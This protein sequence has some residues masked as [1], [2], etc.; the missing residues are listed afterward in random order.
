M[1]GRTPSAVN[2]ISHS[3]ITI[4]TVPFCPE[5]DASLSPNVGILCSNMRTFAIRRPSSSSV[6][7]TRSTIPNWPFFGTFD[8]SLY[9]ESWTIPL[10]GAATVDVTKPINT[11]L[12]SIRVPSFIIPCSSN[13]L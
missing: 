4:P 11:V 7:N 6:I 8:A 1:S 3:R 2:G 12:S 5:R 9:T 13:L 10:S